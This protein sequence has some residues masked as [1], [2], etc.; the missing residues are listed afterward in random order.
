MKKLLQAVVVTG[1]MLGVAGAFNP[2]SAEAHGGGGMGGGHMGGGMSHSGSGMHRGNYI[3]P[4]L[5]YPYYYPQQKRKPIYPVAPIT[6]II[7]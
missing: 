7:R 1:L 5:L 4:W 3:N 6:N 2:T